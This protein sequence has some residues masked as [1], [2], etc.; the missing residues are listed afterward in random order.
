MA[1][2]GQG[3]VPVPIDYSAIG[4]NAWRAAQSNVSAIGG[5]IDAVKDRRDKK[6]AIKTSKEL[7]KAMATLYPESAGALQP[8]IAQLDD[9]EMPLSERAALGAQI[10]TFIEMGVQKSRDNALMNLEVQRLGLEGRRVAIAEALPQMEA[11]AAQVEAT[12]ENDSALNEAL[13]RYVA[14]Q[15]AEAPLAG[16]LPEMAESQSLISKY[17]ERGEGQNALKAV[18]AYEKA[19]IN[20]MEPL[21]GP[22]GGPKLARIGATDATGRGVDMDV[23]VTPQGGVFDL[24][25]NPLNQTAPVDGMV[26]PPRDDVPQERRTVPMPQTQIGVRPARS[27]TQSP[28][29]VQQIRRG[30]MGDKRLAEIQTNAASMSGNLGSL[31]ETRALLDKVRTGFGAETITAAKRLLPGVS[32]ANE[33]QLQTL[34]GDQVMA[35]VAQ[36]KGAVSE[37]EMD[38]FQQYSANFGKTP[39]GNKRIVDFAI[40]AAE[41][42]KKIDT[43]IT[44]GLE[45]GKSPFE[46]QRDIKAIQDSEPLESTLSGAGSPAGSTQ[47]IQDLKKRLQGQ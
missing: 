8:V 5:V 45:T 3:A 15:E 33:E 24:Q 44:A 9:E 37:K 41:R 46:I 13:S 7:A 18:E 6:D 23:F 14:I 39:E 31:R 2:I 30:E 36:T 26:L 28:E 40:K 4:Q 29:Q 21:M 38:L 27:L 42:A 32:V 47:S 35:R 43:V 20:Q 1:L 10:G 17:I 25:G 34:L 22:E 16:K 12:T 11:Q 19:R